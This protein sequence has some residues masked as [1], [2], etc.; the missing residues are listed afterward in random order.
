MARGR[1]SKTSPPS[2]PNRPRPIISS[3]A[4]VKRDAFRTAFQPRPWHAEA[5]RRYAETGVL[6]FGIDWL[7]SACSRSRLYI[8]RIDPDGSADPEPVDDP[9]IQA[10]INEFAR[11]QSGQSQLIGR[12]AIHIGVVGET[13]LLRV[14]PEGQ[15]PTWVAATASEI[16]RKGTD[17]YYLADEGERILLDPDTQPV[18]RT[19]RPDPLRAWESD[20]PVRALLPECAQ[21]CA[22]NAHVLAC[23]D[24]RLAG[25]GILTVP[26]SATIPPSTQGEEQQGMPDDPFMAELVTAMMTPLEDRSS[27][28]AVVPVVVRVP[29]DA[30]DGIKH[31]TLATPFDS[32]VPDLIDSVTKKIALGMDAPVEIILGL[33]ET[34]HWNADA[35]DS[36]SLRLHVQ[37]MLQTITSALTAKWLPLALESAGIPYDP[38]LVVWADISDLTQEPDRT[39]TAIE[40]FRIN[41]ISAEALL[42]TCGFGEQDAPTPDELRHQIMLQLASTPQ[43]AELVGQLLQIPTTPQTPAAV[44]APAAGP[45]TGQAAQPPVADAGRPEL[46]AALTPAVPGAPPSRFTP[47]ACELAVLRALEVAGKRLLTPQNRGRYRDTDAWQ[48]H[49]RIRPSVADLDKLMDGAWDTLHALHA[50]RPLTATLDHYTRTLVATGKPHT[51]TGLLAALLGADR[52]V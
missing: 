43:G 20:S 50:P 29:D 37:P 32:L 16:E 7:A 41:A 28:A 38:D 12:I 34:N 22:L 8:G 5:W 40:L 51:M 27:A 23:A 35:I 15:R 2:T 10:V 11:G 19:W 18:I 49:T 26:E 30:V 13:Y 39:E 14:E 36:Q 6:R 52:I 4:Y 25:A 42:R 3:A 21:L 33:G 47:E 46:T 45:T 44:D 1:F 48:L 9:R 17:V 24:S 31:I